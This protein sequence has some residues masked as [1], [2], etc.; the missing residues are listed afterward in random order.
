MFF[1]F[2]LGPS[3]HDIKEHHKKELDDAKT[4]A[5]KMNI[6]MLGGDKDKDKD[7]D[8]KE[9]KLDAVRIIPLLVFYMY[10]TALKIPQ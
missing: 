8:D 10:L 1:C 4:Y 3:D 7:K 2:Q 6:V 9:I 5:R